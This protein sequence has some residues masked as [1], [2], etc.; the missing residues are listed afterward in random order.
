MND[1]SNDP[2]AD[3]IVQSG[4]RSEDAGD[5]DA[6]EEEYRRADELGSA[7][8]SYRLGLL[9]YNKGLIS[10]C[11]PVLMRAIDRGHPE[12]SAAVAAPFTDPEVSDSEEDV[13][14][15]DEAGRGNQPRPF[16]LARGGRRGRQDCPSV[17]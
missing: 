2:A 15:G 13:R 9:L 12:A 1:R 14:R 6:A 5:W 10:G 8:G 11:T 4:R 3:A 7:E 16:A 17:C